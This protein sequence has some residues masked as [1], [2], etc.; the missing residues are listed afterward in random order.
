V[1]ISYSD[2]SK[3][4]DPHIVLTRHFKMWRL[5]VVKSL[6][7]VVQRDASLGVS[8][9]RCG[10]FS[11][12]QGSVDSTKDAEVSKRRC[13]DSVRRVSYFVLPK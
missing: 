1:G 9:A 3:A 4:E 11:W 12:D 2:V 10:N 5:G 6:L 7:D 13:Q 8:A